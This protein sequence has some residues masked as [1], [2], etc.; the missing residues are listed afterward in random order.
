M[1]EVCSVIASPES[2]E[3]PTAR[4]MSAGA[5]A[6]SA[7]GGGARP[8]VSFTVGAPP[9]PSEPTAPQHPAP[10]GDS[11]DKE[12]EEG[13]ASRFDASKLKERPSKSAFR[14][15]PKYGEQGASPTA[16]EGEGEGN[17]DQSSAGV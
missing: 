10:D 16:G 14:A 9:T 15:R 8:G 5:T 17:D 11:E 1:L 12:D 6:S 3:L 4:T 13:A 2:V 7:M